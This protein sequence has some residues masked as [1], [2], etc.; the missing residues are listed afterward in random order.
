M[1]QLS[2]GCSTGLKAPFYTFRKDLPSRRVGTRRVFDTLRT[3]YKLYLPR[4]DPNLP[5]GHIGWRTE[6]H[7]IDYPY[8][9][10][11]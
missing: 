5:M 10:C 1:V 8:Q 7:V 9:D 2:S 11:C 4:S 3:P 6:W